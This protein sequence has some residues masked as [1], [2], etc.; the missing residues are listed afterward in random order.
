MIDYKVITMDE[1]LLVAIVFTIMVIILDY[2]LIEHQPNLLDLSLHNNDDNNK[3]HHDIKNIKNI[4]NIEITKTNNKKILLKKRVDNE[5]TVETDNDDDTDTD[6]DTDT[7]TDTDTDVE[8]N[9]YD[10]YKIEKK[11]NIPISK[12]FYT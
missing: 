9:N 10:Y 8:S 3:D 5:S 7:D 4:K 11:E 12:K 1:Y 6:M 2:Y